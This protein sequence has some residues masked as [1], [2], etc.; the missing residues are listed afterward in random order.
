M[1]DRNEGLESTLAEIAAHGEEPARIYL[2]TLKKNLYAEPTGNDFEAISAVI[3]GD[4]DVALVNGS[5]FMRYKHSG[6]PELFSALDQLEMEIPT[7]ERKLIMFVKH[8]PILP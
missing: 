5:Q 7:L 2:E 6:N 1:Q 4:A 3:R 8:K